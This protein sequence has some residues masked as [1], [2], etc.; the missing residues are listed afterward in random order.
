LKHSRGFEIEK[1]LLEI[2]AVFE[3][4]WQKAKATIK[5]RGI[6]MF[7]NDVRCAMCV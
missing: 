5:E 1:T 3:E 7:N 6:F 4:K 2:M